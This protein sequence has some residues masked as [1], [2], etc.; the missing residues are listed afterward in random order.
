MHLFHL[1][2]PV[3]DL[4]ETRRFYHDILQC[5]VG[6][7]SQR[8][9]DFDFHGHQI[10]AHLSDVIAKTGTNPVDGESVPVR[11]FGAILDMIAWKKLAERLQHLGVEFLI[12]PQIRFAGETGEQAT[13]FIRDPSGNALEFKAFSD[14]NCIF[15]K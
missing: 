3:N 10:T 14:A 7:E 11:H 13:L 4:N 1:A 2:F 15:K 9:I 5:P 12:S 6:R 8:W